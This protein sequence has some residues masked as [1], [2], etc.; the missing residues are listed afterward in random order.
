MRQFFILTGVVTLLTSCFEN[1]EEIK[2]KAD[3]SGS[4]AMIVNLSQSR[5]EIASAM[6]L[7]SF[8]GM[9]LP[10]LDDIKKNVSE[11][12][13]KL[14][15][16]QGI[17]NVVVTEDYTNYIV[18]V[19]GNFSSIQ[20]FNAAARNI[21]IALG[22]DASKIQNAYQYTATDTG[23]SRQIYAAWD[24]NG[25][26]KAENMAGNKINNASYTFIFK[27]EK[28]IASVSNPKAKISPSGKAVMLK[29]NGKDLLSGVN[30]LNLNI[31]YK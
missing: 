26:R 30:P 28:A 12:K 7:D 21:P 18:E 1:S 29:L 6:K 4:F 23:F 17:S 2:I 11:M 19:K 9:N 10:S 31:K 22:A 25:R 5:S 3:G 16:S 15:S 13:S 8:F 27:S 20:H 14:N 24:E